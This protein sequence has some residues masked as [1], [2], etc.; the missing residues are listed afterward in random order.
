MATYPAWLTALYTHN[1]LDLPTGLSLSV[2]ETFAQSNI[3]TLHYC[4]Q[5]SFSPTLELNSIL[6]SCR[7]RSESC[8]C[9]SPTNLFDVWGNWGP[10]GIVQQ[11]SSSTSIQLDI[12]L[13]SVYHLPPP[14]LQHPHFLMTW[15]ILLPSHRNNSELCPKWMK[16]SRWLCH[17]SAPLPCHIDPY[18]SGL[19][20]CKL[21]CFCIAIVDI[22]WPSKG[23]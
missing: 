12:S 5:A 6:E 10:G 15:H 19:L 18:S 14:R 1:S 21:K 23:I 2:Q 8:G 7:V 4:S 16:H 3:K 17:H 20:Y 22:T 13:P 11:V 9:S